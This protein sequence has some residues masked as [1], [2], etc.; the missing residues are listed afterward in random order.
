MK[1]ENKKFLLGVATIY[2]GLFIALAW[3]IA[4]GWRMQN[5]LYLITMLS[6]AS[7]TSVV[8]VELLNSFMLKK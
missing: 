6:I 8:T 2:V 3:E 7:F 4:Q 5:T 1:K